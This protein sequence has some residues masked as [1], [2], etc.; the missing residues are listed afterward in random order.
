MRSLPR[1][2]FSLSTAYPAPSVPVL[3]GEL[4]Q[5]PVAYLFL[6]L[7]GDMCHNPTYEFDDE[8]LPV[9]VAVFARIVARR[10]G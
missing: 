2:S 7:D 10:L 6:G 3:L 5:W 4:D 1:L 8:L 9:A